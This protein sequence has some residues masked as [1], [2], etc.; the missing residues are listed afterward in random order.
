VPAVN[1]C[2][3]IVSVDLTIIEGVAG[4][5][6]EPAVVSV[7]QGDSV[8]IETI[9]GA[10]SYQWL[11]SE[12]LNCDSCAAVYASPSETTD[13]VVIATDSL[14]CARID[15]IKVEVDIQCTDAFLP[16]V[17]SPNGKG[18]AANEK[19]CLLST[20]ID[21]FKLVIYNRWGERIFETSDASVCWD[22]T[23]KGEEAPTGAYAYNLFLR[24]LDGKVLNKTGTL[25]LLK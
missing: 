17:F 11:P 6:V 22:G 23:Y 2:D 3:S 19:F 21:E 7:T 20:C 5:L 1:G 14:G 10:A 15:T 4:S 13:Y 25:S 24:Q 8:F 16:T 12:G 18:P 9:G